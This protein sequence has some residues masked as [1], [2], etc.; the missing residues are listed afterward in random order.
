MTIL[1]LNKLKKI[2]N[3]IEEN[4]RNDIGVEDCARLVFYTPRYCNT[5]FKRY[6]G[7]SIGDYLTH[8]RMQAAKEDLLRMRSVEQVA[9]SLSYKSVDGFSRAFKRYFSISPSAYL[10]GSKLIERYVKDYDYR[11]S[12]SDWMKGEN[13]SYRGLWEYAYYNP[14]TKEYSEMVWNGFRWDAPCNFEGYSD[15]QWF[16]RNRSWGYGMHPGKEIQAVRTFLCPYDGKVEVF[17][18][19]GRTHKMQETKTNTPV[20]VQLF[21]E[22]TPLSKAVVLTDINALFCKGIC[23]VKKGDRIRLHVDSMGDIRGDGMNLYR[24]RV[25]YLEIFEDKA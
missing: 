21:H 15:P 3:Y 4:F 18:S 6:F 14:K 5:L 13:S 10:S 16:C 24:Q 8:L 11:I 1:F 22:E 25:G 23:T 19:V 20:S 2:L 12:Y 7:E 9:H 17:F